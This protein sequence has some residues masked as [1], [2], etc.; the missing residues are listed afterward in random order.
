MARHRRRSIR[1]I[2]HRW[3]I[4]GALLTV[5]VAMA[6]AGVAYR[7]VTRETRALPANALMPPARF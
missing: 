2:R 6:S 5:V 7:L 3:L 4:L 1:G